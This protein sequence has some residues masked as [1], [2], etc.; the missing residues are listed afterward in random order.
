MNCC[1]D[2]PSFSGL[3]GI[4]MKNQPNIR[5]FAP[6][7]WKKYKN[8]RLQALTDSPDAFG[9]TLAEE[10]SLVNE[11]WRKRLLKGT[12]SDWDL[13]LL[14]EIDGEPVGLAWGHIEVAAP[15]IVHLYQ[16]WVAQ[17]HRRIGI[18]EMMMNAVISWA[19][20]KK[21]NCIELSVACADGSAVRLYE[22]AGFKPTGRIEPLRPGSRIMSQEMRLILG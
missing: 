17:N 13:P 4:G 7:E 16:V 22:R 12:A 2:L 8:L 10:Q 5:P 20:E 3:L 1:S 21:A 15:Y 14:A 9:R 11:D 18:G 19:K 6:H